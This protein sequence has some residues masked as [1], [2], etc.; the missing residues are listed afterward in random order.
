MS[1]AYPEALGMVPPAAPPPLLL[2]QAY[3]GGGLSLPPPPRL[4]R[5][6]LLGQQTR[7]CTQDATS[8]PRA[9][10]AGGASVPTGPSLPESDVLSAL[11]PDGGMREGL[12]L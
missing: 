3:A 10:G 7:P 11:L 9:A 1:A 5:V 4:G 6:E 2:D 8:L 12:T